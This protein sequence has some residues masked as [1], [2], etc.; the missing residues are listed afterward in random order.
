MH[1]ASH[2]STAQSTAE[3][4]IITAPAISFWNQNSRTVPALKKLRHK[5]FAFLCLLIFPIDISP[6]IF[7]QIMHIFHPRFAL[8]FATLCTNRFPLPPPPH[9]SLPASKQI[10]HSCHLQF[11]FEL[12]Q[13]NL[14][15]LAANIFRVF[16]PGFP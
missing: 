3:V 16:S 2:A 9:L 15:M 8:L 13:I 14:I 4:S 12:A 7:K 6:A 5:S 10:C 1:P 11:M